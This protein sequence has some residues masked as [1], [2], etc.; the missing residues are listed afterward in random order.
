MHLLVLD[1]HDSFVNNILQ[2]LRQA[3]ELSYD[4]LQTEEFDLRQLD[5]YQGVLLSPG[6][7][8]PS[9][10]PSTGKVL[11]EV[12]RRALPTLGICLGHQAIAEHFGAQ[13][14]QLPAPLHGHPSRL[15]DIDPTD[16]V[17]GALPTGTI[18]GRYHSWAVD[19]ASLPDELLPT[20]YSHE[21]HEGRVI[22]ALRHRTLP[23]WGLQFHPE[24][25][26]TQQGAR[27]LQGFLQ[28]IHQASL[29]L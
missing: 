13:L 27:F 8:T 21:P 5:R 29:T 25:M 4:C 7:C 3:E 10:Y 12:C 19:E 1:H 18:V 16:V 14:Y 9:A 11:E 24:S 22:M 6:P 2:L 23:L 17:V 15:L 26:I 28:H 20:A